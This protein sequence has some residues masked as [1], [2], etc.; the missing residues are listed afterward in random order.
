MFLHPSQA[1][2]G[3]ESNEVLPGH[4]KINLGASAVV[5]NAAAGCSSFKTIY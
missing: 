4:G 3:A 1:K 2:D 5:A